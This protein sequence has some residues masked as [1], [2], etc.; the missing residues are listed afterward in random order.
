MTVQPLGVAEEDVVATLL[1]RCRDDFRR[2]INGDGTAYELPDD[3]TIYGPFGGS[4]VRGGPSTSAMQRDGARK[5]WLAGSGDVELVTGGVSGDIAWLVY[6]E[7]AT[8]TF[9][10][11]DQPRRW[12][13][14]ITDL[15]RRNV[16]GWE[17]FHIHED[18]CVDMRGLDA[19]LAQL[20]ETSFDERPG[21]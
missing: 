18:A 8:V 4:A 17:R 21:G 19:V 7:R 1:D 15:F 16:D 9:R 14:R 2:W 10:G 3:G 20:P 11:L 5:W 12:E 6:I 13:L